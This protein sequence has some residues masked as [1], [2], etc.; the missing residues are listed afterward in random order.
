[1]KNYTEFKHDPEVEELAR[2]HVG[3]GKPCGYFV[4]I[5]NGVIQENNEDLV[6]FEDSEEDISQKMIAYFK[7]QADAQKCAHSI[8]IGQD[9]NIAWV[10]IED[11]HGEMLWRFVEAVPSVNYI[12]HQVEGPWI[13]NTPLDRGN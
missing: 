1:M 3:G 8:Y 10:R 7:D 5:G 13:V 4:S 12:E 9:S 2:K 6:S 11:E